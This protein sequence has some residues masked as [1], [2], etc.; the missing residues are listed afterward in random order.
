MR[1]ILDSDWLLG[2]A[3]NNFYDYAIYPRFWLVLA[4][5]LTIFEVLLTPKCD[6]NVMQE[7]ERDWGIKGRRQKVPAVE[8]FWRLSNRFTTRIKH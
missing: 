8:E 2:V 6:D 5:F 1:S 4:M 3:N 7:G